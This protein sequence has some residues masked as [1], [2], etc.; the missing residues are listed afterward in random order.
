[1]NGGKILATALVTYA[2]ATTLLVGCSPKT[3]ISTTKSGPSPSATTLNSRLRD[4]LGRIN[5]SLVETRLNRTPGGVLKAEVELT[6]NTTSIQRALYRFEWFDG[7]G[8][9]IES[10]QSQQ[11]PF[12]VNPGAVYTLK[13]VAPSEA[14]KDFRLQVLRTK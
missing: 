12:A 2:A 8:A 6:N 13:S 10:M 3:N 9:L 11:M 4:E 1:M 14:A 5:L 7:N